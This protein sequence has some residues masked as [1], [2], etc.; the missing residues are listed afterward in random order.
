LDAGTAHLGEFQREKTIKTSARLLGGY[1]KLD[2]LG[3]RVLG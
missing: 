2:S 3:N 1:D